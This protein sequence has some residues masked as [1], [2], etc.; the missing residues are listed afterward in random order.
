MDKLHQPLKM[1][2]VSQCNSLYSEI[3]ILKHFIHHF[4]I[5]LKLNL[6]PPKKRVAPLRRDLNH[7]ACTKDKIP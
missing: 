3:T 5:L 1:Y 6:F 4:L 7:S 2:E